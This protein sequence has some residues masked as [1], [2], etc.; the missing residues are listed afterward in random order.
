MNE[1]LLLSFRFLKKEDIPFLYALDLTFKDLVQSKE[2]ILDYQFIDEPNNG[3]VLLHLSLSWAGEDLVSKFDIKPEIHLPHQYPGFFQ[4]VNHQENVVAVPHNEG[5]Y[6][7]NLDLGTKQLIKYQS[8]RFLMSFFVDDTFVLVDREGCKLLKLG[9]KKEQ[10]IWFGDKQKVSIQGVRLVNQKV[11]IILRDV[12]ANRPQLYSFDQDNFVLP[13]CKIFDLADLI[14]DRELND[15]LIHERQVKLASH[16]FN[17]EP[18]INTF[19]F[20]PTANWN[21]L[22]GK[23][24]YM[25]TPLK[26]SGFSPSTFQHDF[27]E[28]LLE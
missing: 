14:T 6:L 18:K 3:N 9:N 16:P 23:I 28:I 10:F 5:V 26:E 12:S 20:R 22:V 25:L 15:H 11:Y 4:L 2:L 24:N 21:T 8:R 1:P 27:L 19:S 13:H 17:Y 7:L